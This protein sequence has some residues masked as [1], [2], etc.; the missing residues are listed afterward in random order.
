MYTLLQNILDSLQ[1]ARKVVFLYDVNCT[2]KKWIERVF[3]DVS[4]RISIFVIPILHSYGHVFSCQR[5]YNPKRLEGM[6]LTDGE[7]CERLWS[8]LTR[9]VTIV[10]QSRLPIFKDFLNYVIFWCPFMIRCVQASKNEGL[11]ASLIKCLQNAQKLMD[12]SKRI[13]DTTLVT[14]PCIE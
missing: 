2:F 5:Q 12:D 8:Q 10:R 11:M 4:S 9:T 14:N 13:V 6:G 3:P 7:D 1:P